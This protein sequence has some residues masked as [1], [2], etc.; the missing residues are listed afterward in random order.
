MTIA[1]RLQFG[2]RRSRI[3]ARACLGDG[4]ALGAAGIEDLAAHVRC[5][6]RG[7]FADIP[8]V[9]GAVPVAVLRDICEREGGTRAPAAT[10]VRVWS[11]GLYRTVWSALFRNYRHCPGRIARGV[12]PRSSLANRGRCDRRCHGLRVATVPICAS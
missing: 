10:G 6:A 5:T 1:V 8:T 12:V 2:N 9:G 11:R 3:T 7:T 4:C